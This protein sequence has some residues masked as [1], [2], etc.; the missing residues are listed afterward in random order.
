MRK[1]RLRFSNTGKKK[2][3]SIKNAEITSVIRAV[4][5]SYKVITHKLKTVLH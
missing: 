4:D 5:I 3:I 1:I 2:I